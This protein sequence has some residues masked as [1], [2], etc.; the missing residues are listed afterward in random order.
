MV[1]VYYVGIISSGLQTLT[2]YHMSGLAMEAFCVFICEFLW[3]P[4]CKHNILVFSKLIKGSA[5]ETCV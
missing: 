4:C 1:S 5:V 2:L 3:T